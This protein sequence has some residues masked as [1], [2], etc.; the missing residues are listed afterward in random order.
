MENWSEKQTHIFNTARE[1]FFKEGTKRVTVEAICSKAQV[2]K[3][4]YYKYFRNKEAMILLVIDYIR[5]KEADVFDRIKTKEISFREKLYESLE[6]N[7]KALSDLDDIFFADVRN[8]GVQKID[9]LMDEWDI[10]SSR[11]FF[12]FVSEEQ[13]KGRVRSDLSARYISHML[14]THMYDLV[15]DPEMIKIIPSF[16][17]RVR[18]LVDTFLL[19]ILNKETS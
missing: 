9:E 15:F 5:K 3:R 17:E 1:M 8:S 4:T 6:Y 16:E 18:S 12:E 13:A 14:T 11:D 10:S 7:L 19:G 2:S